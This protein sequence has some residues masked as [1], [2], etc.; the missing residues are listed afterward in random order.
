MRTILLV[1][2]LAS[3]FLLF[4]RELIIDLVAQG[5]RVVCAGA[6]DIQGQQFSDIGA[7]FIPLP[8]HRGSMNPWREMVF[9]GCL[10]RL[11]CHLRPDVAMSYTIKPN[12]YLPPLARLLGIPTVAVA[13][14]LGF[15]FLSSGWA[16]G[17]ARR[18]FLWGMSFAEVTC[19]LN[20]DDR[21]T[22]QQTGAAW[23][24]KTIILPGEG[25]DTTSF[26]ADP[27]ANNDA[28]TFLLIARLLGD[29][30]VREY[31]AAAQKIRAHLPQCRFWLLGAL[32]PENPSG[33]SRPELD[34]LIQSGAIEYHGVRDDVR[35]FIAA[36]DCV[37]LPSYREGV[38][39]VLLEAGAMRRP[40]IATNVPGCADVVV[41]GVN[42]FLCAPRDADSLAQAIEKF[43]A[44][45]PDARHKMG[46]ESR[47]RVEE[48]FSIEK[49]LSAYRAIL[50]PLL[51]KAGDKI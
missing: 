51:M 20:T 19:V 36:A 3:T 2:N 21:H 18:V 33:I 17:L 29:K 1:S 38:P 8:I 41:D 24:K 48:N 9:I 32:D 13:T 49:V 12:S 27:P 23:A 4:R 26:N 15:A 31:G 34:Q 37:V 28:M 14:G 16:A 11:L 46:E 47:R 5:N 7:Q 30:G 45:T 25:V 35:P 40:L 43:M 22:V 42:G 39:R 10:F 6:N 50:S 44:L